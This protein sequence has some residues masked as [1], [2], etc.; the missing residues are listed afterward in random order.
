LAFLPNRVILLLP[1]NTLLSRAVVV[2]QV[3]EAAAAAAAG[4]VLAQGC[5]S[6]RAIR[7]QSPLVVVVQAGL[8]LQPHILLERKETLVFLAQ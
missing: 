4:S 2:P 8:E 1:S 6:R 3:I 7:T 5:L